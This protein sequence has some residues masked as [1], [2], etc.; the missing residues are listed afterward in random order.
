MLWG[1]NGIHACRSGR[2][3]FKADTFLDG[4]AYQEQENCEPCGREGKSNR[5]LYLTISTIHLL[6]HPDPRHCN[7]YFI[8]TSSSLR[9]NSIH[10]RCDAGTLDSLLRHLRSALLQAP[11]RADRRMLIAGQNVAAQLDVVICELAKLAIIKTD[12]LLLRRGTER[13]AG[14][15]VHQKEDDAGHDERVREAGNTVSELEAE[16]DPVVIEP[17]TRDHGETVEMRNVVAATMNGLVNRPQHW[18]GREEVRGV[19]YA[20]KKAVIRLPAIPPTAC[21][22]KISMASSMPRTN[23]S[24]V[25]KLQTMAPTTPKTTADQAGT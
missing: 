14:D 20:A 25:A 22:A 24:L 17:A 4:V 23:L 21:S 5:Y 18:V 3:F 12:I 13:Q 7:S 6:Q 11:M 10:E 15:E 2:R 1:E 16:L 19:T 8:N 9:L